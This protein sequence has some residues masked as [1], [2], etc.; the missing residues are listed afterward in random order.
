MNG[1]L[2]Q[3]LCRFS[4][5]TAINNN[6]LLGLTA[7]KECDSFA[8]TCVMNSIDQSILVTSSTTNNYITIPIA[9]EY[10]ISFIVSH[11]KYHII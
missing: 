1:L 9:G 11:Q 6:A 2:M 10:Y 8:T 5:C 4:T 7:A 3:L